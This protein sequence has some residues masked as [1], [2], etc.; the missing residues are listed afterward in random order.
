M[1]GT[2]PLGR[3]FGKRTFLAREYPLVWRPLEAAYG[4]IVDAVINQV[5]AHGIMFIHLYRHL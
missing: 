5:L 1:P 4:D 2:F 3:N